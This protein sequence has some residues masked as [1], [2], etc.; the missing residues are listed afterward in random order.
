MTEPLSM[1]VR[2]DRWASRLRNDATIDDE[3]MMTLST[4]MTEVANRIADTPVVPFVEAAIGDEAHTYRPDPFGE[5][6]W[7]TDTDHFFDGDGATATRQRWRLVDED[8]VIFRP[9]TELCDRCGGEGVI[10]C[11]SKP[12]NEHTCPTCKGDGRHPFAGEMEV[13]S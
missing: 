13:L 9:R 11:S 8:T 3:D 2:L 6:G 7:V 12:G 1:T 4:L 10:P 5:Y